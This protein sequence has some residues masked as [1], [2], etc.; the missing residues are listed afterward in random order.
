MS[1]RPNDQPVAAP[2]KKKTKVTRPS[3]ELENRFFELCHKYPDG[4]RE[5]VL[6][7]EM[8]DV[9]VEQRKALINSLAARRRLQFL[10]TGGVIAYRLI[11]KQESDKTGGMSQEESVVYQL[12]KEEGAKGIW[13][14]I[15]VRKS[16]LP[17]V[18]VDKILKGL[19]NQQIIKAVKGVQG[20]QKVYM[21][22]ELKPDKQLSVWYDDEGKFDAEFLET[23]TRVCTEFLKKK[24]PANADQICEFAKS[25]K[26]F[27]LE[28]APKASDLAGL[29]FSM[30]CDADSHVEMDPSSLSFVKDKS[31]TSKSTRVVYRIIKRGPFQSS[32]TEIPCCSCPIQDRCSLNGL[33]NPVSCEYLSKWLQF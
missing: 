8:Q 29:L 9:D 22:Y 21:L 26:I 6:A 1:K 18:R 24:G 30:S 19:M 20:K 4:L 25:K 28:Q 7:K 32:F 16:H 14:R 11:G 17:P 10:Q 27:D 15:I 13:R 31:E 23:A 2:K 33:V 12:V 5:D 3:K